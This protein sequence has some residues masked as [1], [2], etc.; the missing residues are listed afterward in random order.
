MSNAIKY[1]STDYAGFKFGTLYAFSNSTNFSQ[2]RAYSFGA[3]Y[4]FGPLNVAAGYL[5]TNGSNSTANTGGAIA[6][7]CMRRRCTNT[8]SE[9]TL[10]RSSIHQVALRRQRIKSLVR[11]EFAPGSKL[12]DV[13]DC[14]LPLE[15]WIR[16]N[17]EQSGG[18]SH[19]DVFVT[20]IARVGVEKKLAGRTAP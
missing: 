10:W 4:G 8:R 16:Q 20:A 17:M 1:M 13:S 3:S 6:R 5:Q 19:Y 11:S 14:R 7:T 2:N 12:I 18:K 15:S 9:T